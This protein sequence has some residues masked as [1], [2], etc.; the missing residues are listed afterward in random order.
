VEN[1]NGGTAS[2]AGSSYNGTRYSGDVFCFYYCEN[3]FDPKATVAAGNGNVYMNRYWSGLIINRAGSVAA[4]GLFYPDYGPCYLLLSDDPRPGMP[5]TLSWAFITSNGTPVSKNA[6]LSASFDGGASWSTVYSGANTSCAY[7]VPSGKDGIMFRVGS[8]TSTGYCTTETVPFTAA[9]VISGTDANLGVMA[10]A[11]S[12]Y[13]YS[14]ARSSADTEEWDE[15]AVTVTL[16]GGTL[17]SAK[18]AVNIVKTV[19]IGAAEWKK[20]PNGEHT[21]KISARRIVGGVSFGTAAVRTLTFT[22]TKNRAMLTLR[23]AARSD[24]R[25]E[26]IMLS[27]AGAFPSGSSLSVEAC[28]NAN[29]SAPAWEDMTA[30]CLAGTPRAFANGTKTAGE[31]GVNFR[32]TLERGTAVGDCYI[33]AVSGEYS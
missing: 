18:A 4:T 31:W 29:D 15:A 32:I 21:L 10:D 26:Q 14:V 28:N 20:V 33:N 11:F 12:P 17:Q 27:V 9:P 8:G 16:D 1:A 13:Q 2:N 7:T 5:V 25:P 6:T 19:L 23:N 3:V 30:E 22:R 24:T